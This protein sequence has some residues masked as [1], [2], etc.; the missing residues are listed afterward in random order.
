MLLHVMGYVFGGTVSHLQSC[1]STG[2]VAAAR[3]LATQTA[4][5]TEAEG[6][7]PAA[8][9]AKVGDTGRGGPIQ[10]SAQHEQV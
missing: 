3:G 9:R 7:G 6:A 2:R 10:E 5:A 4:V 1:I 8:K